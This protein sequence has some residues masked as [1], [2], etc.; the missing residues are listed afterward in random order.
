MHIGDTDQAKAVSSLLRVIK[1]PVSDQVFV[2]DVLEV[3]H[4][5]H[6]LLLSARSFPNPHLP[7]QRPCPLSVRFPA[8]E[9][10]YFEIRPS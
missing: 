9:C 2:T 1:L 4:G 10:T 3:A 5:R 8:E 6:E 7:F